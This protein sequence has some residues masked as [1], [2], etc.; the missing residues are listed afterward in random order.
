MTLHMHAD[1]GKDAYAGA[2]LL[3]VLAAPEIERPT[4]PCRG[5]CTDCPARR[6]LGAL[7]EM[8]KAR[9]LDLGGV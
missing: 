9:P 1:F 7:A 4:R 3:A 2:S 8:A 6:A 5:D